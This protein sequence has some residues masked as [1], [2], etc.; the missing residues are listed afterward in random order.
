MVVNFLPAFV[1][2]SC[3]GELL[4]SSN[5]SVE[6]S[7]LSLCSMSQDDIFLQGYLLPGSATMGIWYLC[8]REGCKGFV[9][10]SATSGS[11]TNHRGVARLSRL[12]YLYFPSLAPNLYLRALEPNLYLPALAPNLY[13]PTLAPNVCWPTLAKNNSFT[14]PGP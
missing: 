12:G 2:L 5:F 14:G 11:V 4:L 6:M 3:G 9:L 7:T 8:L 10:K 13:L 1:L